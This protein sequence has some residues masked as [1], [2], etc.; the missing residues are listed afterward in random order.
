MFSIFSFIIKKKKEGRH[1]KNLSIF[2]IVKKKKRKEKLI[3]R[4]PPPPSSTY[5]LDVLNQAL[6][7]WLKVRQVR[8]SLRHHVDVGCT[9]T[10]QQHVPFTA[11]TLRI[12]KHQGTI[13]IMIVIIDFLGAPSCI[14]LAWLRSPIGACIYHIHRTYTRMHA[15]THMHAHTCMCVCVWVCVCVHTHMHA[16]MCVH[17]CVHVCVHT[18]AHTHARTHARTHTHKHTYTTY[19]MHY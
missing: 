12:L 16:C 11:C 18:H 13:I 5:S 15:H 9:Q 10:I 6:H 2:I 1:L 14:S 17:A 8:T 4:P 7:S 19:N 3:L